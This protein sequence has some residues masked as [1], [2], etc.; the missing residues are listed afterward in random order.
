MI[1][2]TALVLGAMS[3][4]TGIFGAIVGS[5]AKR[6]AWRHKA[7]AWHAARRRIS[8]KGTSLHH[9]PWRGGRSSKAA[10][11]GRWR[12]NVLVDQTC[13]AIIL[14]MFG[15]GRLKYDQFYSG[16]PY[17]FRDGQDGDRTFTGGSVEAVLRNAG[18]EKLAQVAGRVWGRC[19]G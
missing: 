3:V 10:Q 2:N 1:A 11:E 15:D 19:R 5:V 14:Q 7:L 9:G 4:G 6:S 18:Y 12:A 17:V 13:Q 8:S 16:P